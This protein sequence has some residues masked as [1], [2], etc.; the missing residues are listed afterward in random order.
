M[1]LNQTKIS[2]VKARILAEVVVHLMLV[3]GEN[4]ISSVGFQGK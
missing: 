3:I 1:T 4:S 2:L